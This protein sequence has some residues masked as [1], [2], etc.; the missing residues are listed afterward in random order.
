MLHQTQVRVHL[1]NIRDNIETLRRIIGPDRRLL[2]P[3]KGNAY[4]HGA[5]AVGQLAAQCGVDWLGVATVSEGEE[6]RAAGLRLPILVLCPTLPDAQE[7]ALAAGLTLTISSQDQA[8]ALQG[9]CRK[10]GRTAQVHLEFETGMGRSGLPTADAA[11][12]AGFLASQCPGLEI[13]GA[14]THLPASDGPDLAYTGDQVRRFRAAVAQLEAGLGRPL[15][16]VHCANSGGVLRVPEGW[17]SMVRP[18]ISV[19]GLYTGPGAGIAFKPGLSFLTRLVFVRP[20]AAGETV[21]YGRTWTAP[22]DTVIGT[23]GCGYAEGFN[24]LFSNRGRVLV[25]GRACPVVGRVCMNQTMVD[26]GPDSRDLPGDVAVLIGR[27]GG[28]EITAQEWAEALGTITYEVATQ[29]SAR[30]DRVYEP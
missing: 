2:V 27:S 23:L 14:S 30:V 28:L 12:M 4:G 7:A 10:L 25:N 6:L 1:G 24:R 20:A 18:G 3:V 19:Y 29:I 11:A 8:S 9:A 26:L 21:G 13:Q 5:V 17:L 15:E 16:L 22:R